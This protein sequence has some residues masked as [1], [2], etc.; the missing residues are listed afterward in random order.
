MNTTLLASL[1]FFAFFCPERI[2][3]GVGFIMLAESQRGEAA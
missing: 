1:S 2:I 3:S